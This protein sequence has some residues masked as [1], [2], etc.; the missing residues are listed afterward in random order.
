VAEDEPELAWLNAA[1]AGDRQGFENLVRRHQDDVF[2][3]CYRMLGDYEE[4]RD[5]AQDTFVKAYRS[6][7]QFRREARFST[8]LYSIAV[9]TCR[10]RLNSAAFRYRKRT[11]SLDPPD[12]GNPRAA[13]QIEDPAP[14]PLNHL[15]DRERDALVQQAIDQ[16]SPE[17]KVMVVLRDVE[18]LAYEEIAGMTGLPLGTVKSRLARARQ[19]IIQ[20]LK[21][22]I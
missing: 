11:V 21:G 7:K 10:N 14:S 16:L 20:Q 8:W 4:A 9:N 17:A 1:L 15:A 6:L 19:Q 22:V 13:I 12:E 5:G 18:G 3:L 2:N